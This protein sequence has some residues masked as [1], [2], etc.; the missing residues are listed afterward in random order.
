MLLYS[1]SR[2]RRCWRCPVLTAWLSGAH[3]NP[4]L[5]E[6]RCHGI[7]YCGTTF[8]YQCR[9]LLELDKPV[10][11]QVIYFHFFLPGVP[12]LLKA[13]QEKWKSFVLLL[14]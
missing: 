5:G 9:E 2:P 13:Q 12:G 3:R 11:L 6:G 8:N 4:R 7:K 1:L 10:I 14:N